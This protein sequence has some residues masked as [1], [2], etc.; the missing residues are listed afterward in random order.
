MIK[1]RIEKNIMTFSFEMNRIK[2]SKII[3]DCIAVEFITET[4]LLM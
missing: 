1:V 4:I 2:K 3:Y